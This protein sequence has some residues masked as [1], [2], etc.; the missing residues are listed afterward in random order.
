MQ[1]RPRQKVELD[2]QIRK[3]NYTSLS[4]PAQFVSWHNKGPFPRAVIS[5]YE[6]S[7]FA[8]RYIS[9]IH[10][11]SCV[12][13]A[14][15]LSFPCLSVILFLWLHEATSLRVENQLGRTRNFQPPSNERATAN[16]Y[17]KFW[18]WSIMADFV[19]TVYLWKTFVEDESSRNDWG[20][21]YW[22]LAL[23]FRWSAALKAFPKTVV[24]NR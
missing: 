20:F 14:A 23:I 1:R 3:S 12:L 10:D 17:F 21:G 24:L 9:T 18:F 15:T 11:A 4:R 8:S 22:N 16:G 2:R 19:Y 13:F 6:D 5:S 7:C